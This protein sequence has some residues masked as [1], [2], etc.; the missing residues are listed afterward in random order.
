M[1]TA[2]KEKKHGELGGFNPEAR[3]IHFSSNCIYI[4]IYIIQDYLE[5]DLRDDTSGPEHLVVK[6]VDC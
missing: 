4:Y 6:S 2:G 1:L 3:R 5:Q